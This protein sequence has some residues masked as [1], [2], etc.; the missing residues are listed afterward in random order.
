MMMA[1]QLLASLLA[2]LALGWL[3]GR[4]GLGGERR[5]VDE[6]H[7]VRLAAEGQFGFQGVAAAVDMAGYSAL[8]RDCANHHV[9]V[10]TKGNNFVTRKLRQPIEGRLDQKFL[11][12]DVQEPDLAPVTLNLGDTAQY[13]AAGLRH[14]P[15]V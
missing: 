10:T 4:L 14:V 15:R 1:L 9:L 2:V 12:I 3:A 8:V 7:A 11:T 5:L 13:W 6:D